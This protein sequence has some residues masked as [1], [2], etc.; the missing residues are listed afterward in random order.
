MNY[1]TIQYIVGAI[2][3]LIIG[4][5]IFVL[6]IRI[7]K[8]IKRK[9]EKKEKEQW[10][11][12]SIDQSKKIFNEAPVPYF[13]LNKD[14]EIMD[15]NKAGLRFF[16]VTSE[17]IISKNL[18]Q[19]AVEEDAEYAGYLM[20][21]TSRGIPVT[22]KELRVVTKSGDVQ[23][24][25]LSVVKIADDPD[26]KQISLATIFDITEQKKLDQAKTEFVSLT[27]H[28]LR[29][30]LA[31]IRWYTEMLA[32]PSVGELNQKQRGYVSTIHEVN[33]DMVE[34]VDTLLNV[35]RMEIGRVTVEIVPTNVEE[36]TESILKELSFHIEKKKINI[37]KK[38]N[39]LFTDVKSDPK[40]LRIVIHNLISNAIKYTPEGGDVTISFKISNGQNQ[41]IVSDTGL[42][43]PASEQANIF[44]K[45]FRAKNVKGINSSQSTGLGLYLVKSLIGAMGGTIS[46]HS[47]ENKG[48]TF[49]VTF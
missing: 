38:Y 41:V 29:A 8:N 27:S 36:V 4:Y 1:Q 48:S 42:G 47:I 12:V 39:G 45:L 20:T 14:G 22:N 26:E 19:L 30:P 21:C 17:E 16:G 18:F 40:I 31:T 23:W 28:Q 35:S 49:I 10:L 37:I 43:I 32:N 25:Q 5:L 13:I 11:S 6:V 15:L 44:T 3:L 46:F 33:T 34:L 24:V 7:V 2:T 9:E